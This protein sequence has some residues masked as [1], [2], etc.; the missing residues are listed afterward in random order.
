MATFDG[1]IVGGGHNGLTLGAY[2]T[3]AGLRVCVLEKNPWIGGGCTTDEPMLP[4]YRCNM[5][6]NF[7]IGFDASPLSRDFT[8][9]IGN[10]ESTPIC[11]AL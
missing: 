2:L 10:L 5:H 6:S 7:Y 1:V 9:G 3:R 4:G 8:Y 11:G